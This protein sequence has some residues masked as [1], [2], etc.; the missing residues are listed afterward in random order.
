MPHLFPY[1]CLQCKLDKWLVWKSIYWLLAC[2]R[3]NITD[4]SK[5]ETAR[6]ETTLEIPKHLPT[7]VQCAP[8]SGQP[9]QNLK[10]CASHVQHLGK[11]PSCFAFELPNFSRKSWNL[12][13][14]R[15]QMCPAVTQ[16]PHLMQIVPLWRLQEKNPG[17]E[18][19]RCGAV[20]LLWPKQ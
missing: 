12:N 14:Q 15:S 8:S 20:F 5:Q 2:F 4:Y 17:W 1:F 6:K 10:I 7:D 13:A 19:G 18:R 9:C 11:I 16:N 3:Q